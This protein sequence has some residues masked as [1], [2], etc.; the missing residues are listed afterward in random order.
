MYYISC[1]ILCFYYITH[2][3]KIKSE[4]AVHLPQ[5]FHLYF[6][7]FDGNRVG[8]D[9]FPYPIPAGHDLLV[10]LH[11][12]HYAAQ[13]PEHHAAAKPEAHTVPKPDDYAAPKPEE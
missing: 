11:T 3:L 1:K 10:Y 8:E 12:G 7:Y 6:D 9:S 4:C 5:I 13:R 2:A